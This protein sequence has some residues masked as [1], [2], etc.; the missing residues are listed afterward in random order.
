ME[1]TFRLLGI[2][3]DETNCA[4]CGRVDLKAVHWLENKATGE[5]F[6]A[7]S[8]CGP[9]LLRCTKAEFRSFV[10]EE[11][12]AQETA[13][14]A[15]FNARPSVKA[16]AAAIAAENAAKTSGL[17]RIARLQPLIDAEN[18]DRNEAAKLFPLNKQ[19]LVG[20]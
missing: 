3:D 8:S 7:G 14:R 18:A 13:A 15:W 10:S 9:K 12:K 6:P 11:T 19:F 5:V 17:A 20:L 2:N 1:T 16:L 4:V